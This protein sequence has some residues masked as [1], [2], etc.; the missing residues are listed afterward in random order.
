M[1]R[2]TPTKWLKCVAAGLVVIAGLTVFLESKASVTSLEITSI[3]QTRVFPFPNRVSWFTSRGLPDGSQIDA[4]AAAMQP[5]EGV[6]KVVQ[7]N[8]P[9]VTNWVVAHGTFDYALFLLTHP[10]LIFTEPF[11]RPE[12]ALYSDGG[13]L[14]IYAA[15]NRSDSPLTGVLY[16]TWT[17]L[18]PIFLVSLAAAGL[19]AFWRRR[20]CRLM[21][22]LAAAGLFT[23]LFA[24]HTDGHETD[25]HML[26][27]AVEFRLGI[28]LCSLFALNTVSVALSTA[29]GSGNQVHHSIQIR[30]S[31]EGVTR[32]D[33]S[34]QSV[35]ESLDG[36]GTNS[37]T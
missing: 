17:W 2:G 33:R 10:V 8:D 37:S 27:G 35:A 13:V 7:V 18:I 12:L 1:R 19:R 30:R 31:G 25:R 14:Q 11:A 32:D 15:P 34:V 16:G 24:W 28:L 20:E 36:D 4:A 23:M 5:S 29:T 26:E 22:I 6:G 3:Y 21:L 9:A